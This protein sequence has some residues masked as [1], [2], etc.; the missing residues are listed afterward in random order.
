MYKRQISYNPTKDTYKYYNNKIIS[1]SLSV[2]ENKYEEYRDKRRSTEPNK[3]DPR[4]INEKFHQT[5]AKAS[6]QKDARRDRRDIIYSLIRPSIKKN[7]NDSKREFDNYQK[8]YIFN[9]SD[10][11]FSDEKNCNGFPENDCNKTLKY[12]DCSFDHIVPHARGGTTSID[13]AQILCKSC[14]SRKGA[15]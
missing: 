13:N 11:K 6:H 5:I 15:N 8:L 2:F 9:K 14:N 12:E 10:P 7:N 3:I 1:K 4:D